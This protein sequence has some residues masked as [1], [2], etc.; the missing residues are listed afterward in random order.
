MKSLNPLVRRNSQPNLRPM[1]STQKLD[2]FLLFLALVMRLAGSA[3]GGFSYFVLAGYALRGR[4]QAIQALLLSWLFS[5]LS[6]GIAPFASASSIGRYAV[7][8]CAAI[9]VF[10]RKPLVNVGRTESQLFIVTFVFGIF[11]LVHSILFSPLP[12][13]SILKALLWTIVMMTVLRA[14]GGMN[15]Q[16]RIQLERE[17]FGGLVLLGLLSI[18]LIFS[19]I[20]YMRNG[21]GF[22]GVLF[23]PQSFGPTMALL[24]AFVI[25][26]MLAEPKPM[27]R[28]ISMAGLCLV[29]VVLSGA[30]TAALA[31]VLGVTISII[32]I[33]LL[34]GFS[35]RQVVPGFRSGR[36]RIF[37]VFILIGVALNGSM[38]SDVLNNFMNKNSGDESVNIVSAYEKSR[39][40]L[41]DAMLGNI[42]ENPWTGIGFGIASLPTTMNIER[43]PV[44]GLPV[45]A[46]IEKGV[47]PLAVLEELGVV[48]F[49]LFIVWLSLFIMC[50]VR[51]GMAQISVLL[52]L[53]L[54][55]F[56][57]STLFS[58]SGFGLLPIVLIG[59]SVS[60]SSNKLRSEYG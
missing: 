44:F 20:G 16:L 43:D 22:Q 7:V 39:G 28:S 10:M 52:T 5:M 57:E 60:S 15:F 41:I 47:L 26:R 8:L 21:T 53:L 17:L 58:S 24:G 31:L 40:F 56:G 55:N 25:S 3:I 12:D 48:G 42:D 11:L 51:G 27:W 1:A 46:T 50:A 30:R 38:L 33:V 13:V 14:W 35:A 45:S 23:H 54:F 32:I 49:V 4:K 18:P 37:L 6:D 34:R 19:G 9:S 29:F 2:Y 59:W 36:L